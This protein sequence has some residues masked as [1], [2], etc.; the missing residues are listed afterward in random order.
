ML[1]TP[2]ISDDEN[3]FFSAAFWLQIIG[4]IKSVLFTWDSRRVIY[5]S[6][7]FTNTTAPCY[8][9]YEVN[10]TSSFDLQLCRVD[11]PFSI[12]HLPIIPLIN[13]NK[14]TAVSRL[15]SVL[16]E[17]GRDT[18]SVLLP[19]F[20]VRFKTEILWRPTASD[21]KME[22]CSS[23]INIVT[24]KLTDIE[25][26]VTCKVHSGTWII[27]HLI[28]NNI[29]CWLV[30]LYYNFSVFRRKSLAIEFQYMIFINIWYQLIR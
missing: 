22:G 5:W 20:Q 27:I 12:K 1:L 15:I 4:F 28:L 16:R 6:G 24:C 23:L 18:K 8:E 19:K 9:D 7:L 13:F 3:L 14:P 10:S 11:A 25:C 29:E 26:S 17:E 2:K 30:L 21:R